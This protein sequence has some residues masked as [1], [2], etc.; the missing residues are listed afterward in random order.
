MPGNSRETID[1]TEVADFSV[2]QQQPSGAKMSR[3]KEVRL[4]SGSLPGGEKDR[5]IRNPQRAPSS[6]YREDFLTFEGKAYMNGA[7]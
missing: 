7:F 2:D 6:R 3:K 5:V 1:A 4:A